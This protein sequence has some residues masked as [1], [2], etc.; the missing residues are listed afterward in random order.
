MFPAVINDRAFNILDRNRRVVNA[1]HARTFAGRGA[2]SAGELGKIIRLVQTLEGFLPKSAIDEI[3]PFRNQVVDRA[4]AGHSADQLT[5]V[6][7]GNAT[8]HAPRSLI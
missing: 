8:I 5:G 7:E 1:E 2:D 6:A 4:A 3:V